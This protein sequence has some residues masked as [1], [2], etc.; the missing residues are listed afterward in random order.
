MA[1]LLSAT[2][3]RSVT[4]AGI[5]VW[6]PRASFGVQSS[7]LRQSELR[8]RF[9]PLDGFQGQAAADELIAIRALRVWSSRAA[10]LL[11]L[12]TQRRA[13][14]QGHTCGM[15]SDAPFHCR[16]WRQVAEGGDDPAPPRSQPFENTAA[17]MGGREQSGTILRDSP[18]H[19]KSGRLAP[20]NWSKV[21]LA[22]MRGPPFPSHTSKRSIACVPCFS[23]PML[24][25]KPRRAA[26]L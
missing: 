19:Q 3:V 10:G 2:P 17:K 7:I 24:E 21:C 20:Y 15:C 25:D 13:T 4:P 22:A 9:R 8:H 5:S 11:R 14:G 26:V 18:D 12:H 1:R 6:G 16:C 23:M